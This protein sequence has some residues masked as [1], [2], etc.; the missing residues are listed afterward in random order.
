[1]CNVEQAIGI[2]RLCTEAGLTDIEKEYLKALGMKTAR[3]VLRFGESEEE[4]KKDVVKP[5]IDG[6]EI[7]GV[8][9]KSTRAA[10]TVR[11]SLLVVLDLAKAWKE[12]VDMANARPAGPPAPSTLGA[13]PAAAPKQEVSTRT[14]LSAADWTGQIGIWENQWTPKRPFPIN[15]IVGAERALATLLYELKVSRKFTA[16]SLTEIIFTRSYNAD[17]T[18][19]STTKRE[20]SQHE[21]N[22]DAIA[23][24]LGH[25]DEGGRSNFA[26][27][28]NLQFVTA[29]DAITSNAWALR[30]AGYAKEE[31]IDESERFWKTQLRGNLFTDLRIFQTVYV[32]FGWK[33]AHSMRNGDTWYTAFSTLIK[34]ANWMTNEI[35][36]AEKT[37]GGIAAA[38]RRDNT[39]NISDG[40]SDDHLRLRSRSRGRKL[41]HLRPRSD[42]DPGGS[43]R[44]RAFAEANDHT[45]DLSPGGTNLCRNFNVGTCRKVDHSTRESDLHGRKRCLFAH[46]CCCLLY[47]SPSPRDQ[48]GSRM[49]SSA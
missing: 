20:P 9:Y 29:Q 11:V 49:P 39:S 30:W 42:P 5:L 12:S 22:T 1:M 26:F 25:V 32:A 6:V 33:V 34:D 16:L 21:R 28:S 17:G 47:T 14:S 7:E 18:Y 19:N 43:L 48:R 24:S 45:R 27:I 10:S 3:H 8:Q 38:T 35:K 37:F 4:F 2:D 36:A 31:E 44:D 15:E 23:K 46:V 41:D 40:S 13:A